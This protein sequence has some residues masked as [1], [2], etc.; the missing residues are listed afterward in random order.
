VK[1]LHIV[2]AVVA[3]LVIGIP[4]AIM[5]Q[6]LSS[7]SILGNTKVN[8]TLTVKGDIT[9]SNASVLT[10]SAASFTS[11]AGIYTCT[12]RPCVSQQVNLIGGGTDGSTAIAVK[13][14]TYGGNFTTD[15]AKLL[16]AYSDTSAATERFNITKDGNIQ[17]GIG[18]AA[19][20]TCDAAHR[21]IIQY[22]G[23][24]AGVKDKVEVC[25]KD[26]ANAYAWRVLY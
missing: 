11:V 6:G 8:G 4:V 14:Y 23:G 26:A 20:P 13:L 3:A 22:I 10:A 15:G 25:G 19:T 21:G 16:A 18:N 7:P 24:G 12:I 9:G 2:V 17:L 5:A 1:R